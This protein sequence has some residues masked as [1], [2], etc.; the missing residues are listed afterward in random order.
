MKA[1]QSFLVFFYILDQYYDQ[2][3]EEELGG[4]LGMISPEVWGDG[5]PAD[6]S[7][8]TDWKKIYNPLAINEQDIVKRA[9]DFLCYYERQFGF[10]FP[11]TKQWLI[12][13]DNQTIVENAMV[14]AQEMYKKYNYDD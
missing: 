9:Y 13:M 3:Q 6:E 5:R 2:C 14:K 10:K 11:K 8:F 12:T 7:I 1:L 4:F